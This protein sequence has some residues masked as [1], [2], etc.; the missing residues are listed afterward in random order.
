MILEEKKITIVVEKCESS[1]QKLIYFNFWLVDSRTGYKDPLKVDFTY[2]S[3][4]NDLM[5]K[6]FEVK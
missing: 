6:Y 2:K 1:L 5:L 4:I 3:I